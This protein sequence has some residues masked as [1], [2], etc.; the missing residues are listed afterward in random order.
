MGT[1]AG[2]WQSYAWIVYL[3]QRN[4]GLEARW[5]RWLKPCCQVRQIFR[6][7]LGRFAGDLGP[8]ARKRNMGAIGFQIWGEIGVVFPSPSRGLAVVSLVYGFG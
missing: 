5:Y 3:L 7:I 2:L 6:R 8:Y 1:V 4:I